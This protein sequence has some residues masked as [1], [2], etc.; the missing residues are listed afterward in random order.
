MSDSAKPRAL[1]L[2]AAGINCDLETAHAFELAGASAER[3]HV[4]ELA[5]LADP[6]DGYDLLAVPGGFSYG[7]DI[8]AGRVLGD[9]L[10][11]ELGPA[12][13]RFVDRGRPVVGIC[14]GFQVLT[15]S[16][17]LADD[18]A[19]RAAALTRNANDAT[20]AT[21]GRYACRWVTLRAAGDRCVWTRGWDG[22]VELPMAHAEGRLVFRD[23]DARR[24]AEASGRVAVVYADPAG[25]LP[26]DFPAN[27]N[28]SD[29][30][31]AG[32]CDDTGLV[33]GLMPHPERYVDPLQHPAWGRLRADARDVGEPAGLALFRAGV[34]FVTGAI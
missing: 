24:D 28:G 6:F 19:G 16:G 18:A 31:V 20:H 4:N 27:P 34:G 15:Q 5:G 3:R 13:R 22:P 29:G 32:L 33:L 10:G 14:N 8:A 30:G 1:V 12:V 17:L 25:D 21:G 11:R 9:R 26:G 23:A 2:R 7:D